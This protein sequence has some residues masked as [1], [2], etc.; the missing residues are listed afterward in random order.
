MCGIGGIIFKNMCSNEQETLSKLEIIK[1]V[2]HNRGPDSSGI[3]YDDTTF[4][5]H[6]RLSI[7]DLNP[8]G[9]QPMEYGDWIIVFNGE[10]YNYKEL[11]LSLID[12]GIQFNGAS[13]TEVLL[14]L[15]SSKGISKTLELINGIFAFCAYNKMT[16]EF[17]LVRDR[18]GEKPLFYYIDEN[19]TLYFA[20]NPSAIVKAI[21]EKTW[22]LDKDG[23]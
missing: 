19:E 21:P 22:T 18:M 7:I 15:I 1:T 6:N 17:H 10:I 8:T 5:V 16:K 23:L 2:Q 12:D 20:S 4:L 14:A 11:K 3:Y 13:D 9:A